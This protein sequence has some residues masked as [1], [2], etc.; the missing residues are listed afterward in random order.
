[1]ELKKPAKEMF[2]VEILS[3]TP[4]H[5][6]L[7]AMIIK[8]THDNYYTDDHISINTIREILGSPPKKLPYSY[9]KKVA[10]EMCNALEKEGIS[11][12][13]NKHEC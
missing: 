2:Q 1:M 9:P 7:P 6:T 3:I 13:I 5:I 12:S 4:F 10:L 11:T 8:Q